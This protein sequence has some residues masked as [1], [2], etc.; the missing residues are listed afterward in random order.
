MQRYF[1]SQESRVADSIYMMVGAWWS[2]LHIVVMLGLGAV[3]RYTGHS[4]HLPGYLVWM[5]C[6]SPVMVFL[7]AALVSHAHFYRVFRGR[8]RL[9]NREALLNSDGIV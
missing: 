9:E 4:L 5:I 3:D 8:V 1:G 6:M 2:C 7:V